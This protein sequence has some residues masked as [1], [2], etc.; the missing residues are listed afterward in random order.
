THAVGA[1]DLCRADNGALCLVMEWLEGV[2][3]EQ[4]LVELGQVGCLMETQELLDILGPV[5]DTLEKA[6]ELGIVHR[7]IKP[8]NIFLLS[9]KRGVRLLDFGLSRLKSSATLTAVDTVMGSPSYIAPEAWQ[10]G[11]KG[12]GKQADLYSAA[13][14]VF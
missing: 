9:E 2:D 5:T 8:A 7:D 1:I 10:S 4:R 6:H 13:V 12:T 11:S 3:L 14:I